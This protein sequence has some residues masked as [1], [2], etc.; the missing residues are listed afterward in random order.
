MDHWALLYRNILK[1]HDLK[2][3]NLKGIAN[4]EENTEQFSNRLHCEPQQPSPPSMFP[5]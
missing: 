3:K 4:T 1:T 5:H 2:W